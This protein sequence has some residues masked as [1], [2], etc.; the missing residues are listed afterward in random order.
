MEFYE[1][2]CFLNYFLELLNFHDFR[3]SVL[4]L[5]EFHNLFNS[6]MKK[7]SCH[8]FCDSGVEFYEFHDFRVSR[9]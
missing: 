6:Y 2:H 4:V 9:L 8:D 7:N 1:F 3:D 5:C